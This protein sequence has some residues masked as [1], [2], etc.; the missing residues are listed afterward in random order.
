M[1][2]KQNGRKDYSALSQFIVAHVGGSE[3]IKSLTHCV[4]RLR[5]VLKDESL[6]QDD[7]LKNQDGIVS[8]VKKGGQYQV[9]IGSHVTDVYDAVQAYIG[10]TT[11]PGDDEAVPQSFGKKAVDIISGTFWPFLGTMCATG[12][13]KG[14]LGAFSYIGWMDAASGTYTILYALADSFFYFLPI[15]IAITLSDKLNINR[16]RFRF[17]SLRLNS[18]SMR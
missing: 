15:M 7:A 6:A 8:I 11:D 17:T 4:T 13:I 9:V 1:M 16:W 14:L 5:F 2:S 18:C 3:N 10:H 12:I